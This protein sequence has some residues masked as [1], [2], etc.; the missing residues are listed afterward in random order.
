MD[1]LKGVVRVHDSDME[2]FASENGKSIDELIEDM[3]NA[4]WSQ[5]L[6]KDF[7]FEYWEPINT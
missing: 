2:D 7:E 3:V 1:Y 6:D 4:G 5:G